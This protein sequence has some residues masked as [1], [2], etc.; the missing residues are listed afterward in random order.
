M[1]SL[2]S[3]KLE[4][5]HNKVF[6]SYRSIKRL[7]GENSLER[8][9]RFLFGGGLMLL[10]SLSF[11]FYAQLN[12]RI[13]KNQNRETARMLISSILL[14]THARNSVSD[15][16]YTPF[17]NEMGESLNPEDH[18][19]TTRWAFISPRGADEV[20]SALRPSD[21]FDYEAIYKVLQNG[22]EYDRYF[23]KNKIFRFYAP[24]LAGESCMSC[25]LERNPDLALNDI[26]RIVKVTLPVD[27]TE[28]TLAENNAILLVMAILTTVLA[29]AGA[30]AIV[31]YV[32][33][34]PVLH[35]KEVSDRVA[36]GDLDS[37]AKISTGDEFEELCHAFNR[38]LR[39]LVQVQEEIQS[40]NKTL[41]NKVDELAQ[42][43]LNLF[44]MNKLKNEF[45]ATM[46]HELRTPLN[47][48]LGFSDVLYG[49]ENLNDKQKRYLK[50]IS[51]SGQGLLALI[52][53]ILDLAK[54]ES[55][56]MVLKPSELS[57]PDSIKDVM[58]SMLSIAD[59]K[60]I[61][62]KQ[63]IP[64]EFPLLRQDAVKLHQIFYNLLSN[65]IKFTP[66]GGVVTVRA[67]TIAAGDRFGL[68]VEDTGIGIP[69][70]DQE[71]IFEKFRQ[72][73][74]V[75]QSGEAITREYEGT[76]LGLSIVKELCKL[77][78][79]EILLVSEF[80]KGSKFSIILPRWL[81]DMINDD[82]TNLYEM[83]IERTRQKVIKVQSTQQS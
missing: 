42:A 50:N 67:W 61:A 71:K 46:S 4:H 3:V 16:K 83:T 13:V 82:E 21:Q 54:I 41:D 68:M 56:K 12:E 51:T 69:L 7:L 14:Q 8:K 73:R 65:A 44:E 72:G 52:N 57:L 49:A 33:V 55:G 31:R 64:E 47:S 20:N 29:M 48:I 75:T 26:M 78:G 36:Q 39:H 30:Y 34:K 11:Y 80:G 70:E 40:T 15:K 1:R 53:D 59:K 58:T 19:G 28:S 32:I 27:K 10:I 24:I 6:M 79:G 43:N 45:L 18:N 74:N 25:H 77:M 76:G 35:L 22:L 81:P 17:L 38:M 2:L 63:E 62:L 66:E 23:P 60:N 9:C 5:S 37:R